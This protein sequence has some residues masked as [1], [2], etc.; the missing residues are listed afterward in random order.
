MDEKVLEKNVQ[1]LEEIYVE[2]LDEL[3][4]EDNYKNKFNNQCKVIDTLV[5]DYAQK[6]QAECNSKRLDFEI[7]QAKAQR[8]LDS[9]KIANDENRAANEKLKFE[10]DLKNQELRMQADL[11]RVEVDL[12]R[13]ELDDQRLKLEREN[14]ELRIQAD[15]KKAEADLKKV[16]LEGQRLELEKEQAKVQAEQEA[17]RIELEAEKI[18]N[19]KAKAE[20]DI[21]EQKRGFWLGIA[22]IAV[23]VL[24]TVAGIGLTI[25]TVV[26]GMK[27]EET[28]SVR[29]SVGKFAINFAQKTIAKLDHL[30]VG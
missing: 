23:I 13:I 21:R 10:A 9:R 3:I 28:G 1:Q 22:K 27:F 29:S 17:K 4:A 7:E 20:A 16:E 24:G 6:K 18:A 5:K 30:N 12:K 19:D 14:Q 2:N 8:E 25:W 11:K 15:L 26:V